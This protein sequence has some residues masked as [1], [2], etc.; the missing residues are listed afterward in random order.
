MHIVT[1]VD[2]EVSCNYAMDSGSQMGSTEQR[3]IVGL[4]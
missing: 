4:L 2:W 3:L 1:L